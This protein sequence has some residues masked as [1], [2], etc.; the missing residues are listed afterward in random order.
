MNNYRCRASGTASIES[1][2]H[3]RGGSRKGTRRR[4][5]DRDAGEGSPGEP[6]GHAV[7]AGCSRRRQG[8]LTNSQA[9]AR[10]CLGARSGSRVRWMRMAHGSSSSGHQNPDPRS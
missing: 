6:Y 7:T 10:P 2:G 5:R 8:H 3:R 9:Q 4:D 1:N